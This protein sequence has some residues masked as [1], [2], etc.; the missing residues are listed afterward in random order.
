VAGAQAHY[1]VGRMADLAIEVYASV[2]ARAERAHA[3]AV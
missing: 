2:I 3:R 1:D